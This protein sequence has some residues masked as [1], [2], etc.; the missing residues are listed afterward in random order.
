MTTR[1]FSVIVASWKRPLWLRRCLR[2]VASLDYPAFEVIVVADRDSLS[3]IEPARLKTVEVSYANLSEARNAGLTEAAGEVCAFIDD[4][5]VPEPMWLMHLNDAIRRTGADAVVG[6]VRGRNGISFQSRV[7]SVDAEAESHPEPDEGDQPFVPRIAPGC[8]LKLIGTNMAIRRDVALEIGGFDPQLRFFLDDADM[9]M[10][11][12]DAG[13][14]LAVAPLAEIHHAFAP[15]S[16]RT[17]LRAP[18]DLSDI[19]RSTAIYTRKHLG[20]A[21]PEILDRIRIRERARLLRHMVRGTCE[22]RDVGLRIEGLERG[23]DEGCAVD[24]LDS[25]PLAPKPSRFAGIDPIPSGHT[26][27]ADRLY[28]RRRAAL[29]KAEAAAESGQRVSL[30]SFSLTPVRHHL[31]YTASG[32]W[33]QSGGIFGRSVRTEPIVRWCSFAHTVEREMRRVAKLRGFGDKR[34]L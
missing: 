24:L 13:H 32:V 4:D 25:R 10:R 21:D 20:M 15:S 27:I 23:W 14:R 29:R 22:P 8:A 19:G 17:A 6:Y 18:M 26:V 5:A 30:F 1:R 11:L 16:R 33:F 31:R 7:A 28:L 34:R 3:E 12:A 9:S 2:A